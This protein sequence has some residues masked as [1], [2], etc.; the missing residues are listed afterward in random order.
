VLPLLFAASLEATDLSFLD[1]LVVTAMMNSM[2][3]AAA[4]FRLASKFFAQRQFL[5]TLLFLFGGS[6]GLLQ[7][8]GRT[9]VD[10]DFVNETGRGA[11]TPHFYMFGIHLCFSLGGTFAIPMALSALFFAQGGAL[12]V[13]RFFTAGILMTLNPSLAT[14]I[15]FFICVSNYSD[16]FR[17]VMPFALSILPKCIGV[18]FVIKPLWRE[19][20]MQGVFFAELISFVDSIGLPYLAL[21]ASVLF[22]KERLYFHRCLS[23][24]T[25]FAL[26]CVVRQ[27]NGHMANDVAISAIFLPFL[28]INFLKVVDRLREGVTRRMWRGIAMM[29]SCMAIGLVLGSG[30]V[31]CRRMMF[32][33]M[34]GFHPDMFQ[35]A[36]LLNQ[37]VPRG[38]TVLTH[39]QRFNPVSLIAGR[40][41]VL[42]SY[43]DLWLR[44][45]DYLPAWV[46]YEQLARKGAEFMFE[47][48]INYLLEYKPSRTFI[49]QTQQIEDFNLMWQNELWLLLRLNTSRFPVE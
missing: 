22:W 1:V 17:Y 10:E 5:A 2:A 47:Q 35:W 4:M 13:P 36:V 14:T 20:Q 9:L 48:G 6:W 42:G 41:L 26:L 21:F 49:W 43:D 31:T 24:L 29:A 27:G 38:E 33:R 37:M 40:Q 32:T 7:T 19:Y 30:A 46:L 8:F 34:S 25:A 44:G 11:P 39:L 15:A 16:A 28:H 3:A 45:N 23:S 18:R 12:P